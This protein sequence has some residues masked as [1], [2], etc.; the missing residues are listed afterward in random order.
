[1]VRARSAPIIPDTAFKVLAHQERVFLQIYKN[2]VGL[3]TP[4]FVLA[5]LTSE[6]MRDSWEL[7]TFSLD[8]AVVVKNPVI[9]CI[10]NGPNVV[11]VGVPQVAQVGLERF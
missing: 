8:T 11:H 1:M 4:G 10:V 6:L 5:E 9:N 3:R 2:G 7:R